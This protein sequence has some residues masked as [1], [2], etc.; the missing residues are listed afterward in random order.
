M[1]IDLNNTKM[2]GSNDVNFFFKVNNSNFTKY[3]Y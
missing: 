2:C 1:Q 3:M